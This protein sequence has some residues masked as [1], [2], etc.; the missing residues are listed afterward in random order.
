MMSKS[1]C[2]MKSATIRAFV[3]GY[4][5]D[6][7]CGNAYYVRFLRTGSCVVVVVIR[8]PLFES[9][10]P[11]HTP[12]SFVLLFSAFIDPLFFVRL[13]LSVASSC[14]LSPCCCMRS[15]SVV[16]SM[17]SSL[18]LAAPVSSPRFCWP[19][20]MTFPR[21]RGSPAVCVVVSVLSSAGVS[22]FSTGRAYSRVALTVSLFCTVLELGITPS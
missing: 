9:R 18:S 15:V 22:L 12:G 7:N 1:W 19:R 6:V 11:P 4:A 3:C 16:S 14:V 8:F 21:P 20:I 2:L 5:I 17:L 13:G 10:S